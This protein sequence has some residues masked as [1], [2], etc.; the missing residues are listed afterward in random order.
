ML[1]G[2]AILSSGLVRRSP[3]VRSNE[4]IA[5]RKC[6]GGA[7]EG[8]D[9]IVEGI[10]ALVGAVMKRQAALAASNC[11]TTSAGMRPRGLT[12]IPLLAAQARTALASELIV[13]RVVRPRPAAARPLTRRA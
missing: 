8:P 2:S 3:R 1:L 7:D 10:W 11:F 4:T 9:P 13:V 12:S 6:H 5:A